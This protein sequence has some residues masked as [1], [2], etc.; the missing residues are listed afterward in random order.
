MS[1]CIIGAGTAGLCSARQALDHNLI[2]T[3]FE[4]SNE[5]GGTW[6]YN[7]DVGTVNGIDVHSSM[8]TNL[9]QVYI[10]FN[11]KLLQLL[12]K[13]LLADDIPNYKIMLNLYFLLNIS[14]SFTKICNAVQ[15]CQRKLWG[16]QTLKSV[17]R[18][19]R[20]FHHKKFILF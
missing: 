9:R 10:E 3:I 5:I 1:V 6:V 20:T 19:T 8:Y 15:T 11:K 12:K 2:P 17:L 4:L 14:L 7:K 16:S 18:M 13:N